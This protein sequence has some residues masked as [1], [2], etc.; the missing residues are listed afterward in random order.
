MMMPPR[1]TRMMAL[2]LMVLAAPALARDDEPAEAKDPTVGQTYQVPY[3]LSATNHFIVRVKLNGKG[4]F[5]LVVDTGAPA[6]YL[7]TEAAGEAGLEPD[8]AEFFC[9]VDTLE[10]EGGAKLEQMQAR[11]EDIFQLVGMNALGL[12]GVEI[13]GMLGFN[14]LARYRIT[15]DPTAD[16]MEWTRLDYDPPTISMPR[17]DRGKAKEMPAVQALDLLGGLAKVVAL[18][19]GKQPED[20]RI[21]RGFV[22]IEL[23]EADGVVSVAKVLPGSPAEAAGVKAGDRIVDVLG[24]DV[25][26]LVDVAKAIDRVEPG[27]K[28]EIELGSADGGA[29]AGTRKVDVIASEGL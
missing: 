24:R 20:E 14:I 16:R 10:V 19:I 5:N 27:D 6:L 2:G 18:F 25:T 3:I 29:D 8:P 22:G 17:Q 11:V 28:V 7:S 26:G 21:P 12:P 4:P 9:D 23:A 15:I 1:A 13:H